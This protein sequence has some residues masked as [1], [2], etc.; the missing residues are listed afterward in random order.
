[1]EYIGFTGVVLVISSFVG[2][3]MFMKGANSDPQPTL[4]TKQPKVC[5]LDCSEC[6]W[7]NAETCKECAINNSEEVT[8]AKLLELKRTMEDRNDVPPPPVEIRKAND[9][10]CPTGIECKDCMWRDCC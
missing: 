5:T 7:R 9:G 6:V 8:H 4:E 1:M 3:Y 2:L 10:L